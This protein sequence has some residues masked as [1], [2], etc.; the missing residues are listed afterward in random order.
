MLWSTSPVGVVNVPQVPAALAAKLATHR[1]GC[2]FSV[3]V[4]AVL[5]RLTKSAALS[6]AVRR[7]SHCASFP[8]QSP[9]RVGG[10]ARE[11]HRRHGERSRILQ[12]FEQLGILLE[13]LVYGVV[14]GT[15]DL[16]GLL[17][18]HDLSASLRRGGRVPAMRPNTSV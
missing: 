18:V 10:V 14:D 8:R 11:G 15:A 12:L 13:H 1:P 7:V 2:T 5:V 16:V 9:A 4:A 3:P 17:S 6:A